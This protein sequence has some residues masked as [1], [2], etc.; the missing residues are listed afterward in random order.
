L[1]P[2]TQIACSAADKPWCD[3]TDSVLA[4]L[5]L[6]WRAVDR[7]AIEITTAAKV[8]GEPVLEVYG[9]SEA[10]DGEALVAGVRALTVG[11]DARGILF[12]DAADVL[13]VCQPAAVHRK[14]VAEFAAS[15]RPPGAAER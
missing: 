12:D 15:L 2:Q 5:G 9:V 6:A 3:A 4:P 1:W 7:G 11:G 13:M 8:A 14:I 10:A